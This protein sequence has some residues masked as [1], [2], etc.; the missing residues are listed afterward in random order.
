MSAEHPFYCD[1][2]TSA[3]IQ[4]PTRA[5]AKKTMTEEPSAVDRWTEQDGKMYC[6]LCQPVKKGELYEG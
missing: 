1:C 6:P 3:W 5:E 4:A 2:G